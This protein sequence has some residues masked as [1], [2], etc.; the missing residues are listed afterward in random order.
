[1]SIVEKHVSLP[2]KY[3]SK[4][5]VNGLLDSNVVQNDK[6]A[7][8]NQERMI[9]DIRE[10]IKFRDANNNLLIKG[11]GDLI[12]SFNEID[13]EKFDQITKLR[14]IK[15]I[16]FPKLG[17]NGGREIQYAVM[18][19]NEQEIV[20]LPQSIYNGQHDFLAKIF[21]IDTFAK[22]VFDLND[23]DMIA[24]NISKVIDM[25]PEQKYR[26]RYIRS[27]GKDK[28][29]AVVTDER[30]KIYDNNMVLYL[31]LVSL[32]NYCSKMSE[33][34]YID[35][36]FIS[37]SKIKIRVLSSDDIEIASGVR[38]ETGI[39]IYNSE[40]ADGAV[41]FVFTYKVHNANNGFTVL[42][43]DVLKI[44]HGW[45]MDKIKVELENLNRLADYSRDI[46]SAIKSVNVTK[47]MSEEQIFDIFD[48][49]LKSKK[50]VLTD[51]IKKEFS[52]LKEEIQVRDNTINI[53]D[54]FSKLDEITK[55]T[56]AQLYMRF[57]FDK[58][59]HSKKWN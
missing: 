29:R 58:Y 53:L 51:D 46:V 21:K 27:D 3:A 12:S 6:E 15:K 48:K 35:E 17:P 30:Y 32:N 5:E 23:S 36:F 16:S 44:E 31:A 52:E 45:T 14:R 47:N 26:F 59:I 56:D 41:K 24:E 33:S 7:K 9:S 28:L 57:M 8:K 40:L 13:N 42:S 49:L 18:S 34:F 4:G 2:Q 55:K 50:K 1:M 43:D 20:L 22:F 54:L 10:L 11:S 38:I 39:E 19:D 25:I 37:D